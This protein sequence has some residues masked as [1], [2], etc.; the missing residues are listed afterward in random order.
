MTPDLG[1][2]NMW[3]AIMAIVSVLEDDERFSLFEHS[4]VSHVTL[5]GEWA[6]VSAAGRIVRAR[7]VVFC[8]NGYA[9]PA[10]THGTHPRI[11]RIVGHMS[12]YTQRG[13]HPPFAVS[14]FGDSSSHEDPYFYVTG[15]VG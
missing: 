7:E 5:A 2:T 9:L 6:V 10:L 3:L 14:Y 11:T 4:P 12:A 13:A 8:T 15:P 1:T